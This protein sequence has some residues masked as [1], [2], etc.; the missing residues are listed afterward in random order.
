MAHPHN[1]SERNQNPFREFRQ[2]PERRRK[3]GSVLGSMVR[4]VLLVALGCTAGGVGIAAQGYLFFV[5]NLPSVEKLKNYAPPVVTQMYADGGELIAEF[6][7]ETR[8][9][10]PIDR[11][12][13]IVQEAFISAEDKNFR[14]HPGVDREA[15]LRAVIQNIKSGGRGP[16][17]STI[18]QQVARTFLLTPEKKLIR[19]IKEQILAVRIEGS[20]SKE[21]ILHLYLNQ[22]YLGSSAYGVEA[23]AR[24]YFGKHIHEVTIA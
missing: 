21:Q 15:I 8:F 4:F 16:G 9:L 12:P 22:I 5:H 14:S 23:A 10:V 2:R 19:K 20:L 11:I 7:A 13:K 1:V 6:A 18:T 17:G 3:R 24:T